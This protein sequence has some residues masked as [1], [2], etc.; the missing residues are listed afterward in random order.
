MGRAVAKEIAGNRANKR[1]DTDA[2]AYEREVAEAVLALTAG[3]DDDDDA[4]DGAA[5]AA[6]AAAAAA[7]EYEEKEAAEEEGSGGRRRRK[8]ARTVVGIALPK[9]M[10]R[11]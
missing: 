5:G 10:R 2:D 1:Q 3:D 9:G 4:V 8:R 6:G 7:P 11:G